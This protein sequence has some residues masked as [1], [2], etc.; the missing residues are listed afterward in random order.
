MSRLRKRNQATSS[1]RAASAVITSSGVPEERLGGV[2]R[3]MGVRRQADHPVRQPQRSPSWPSVTNSREQRPSRRSPTGCARLSS[4]RPRPSTSHTAGRLD[5]RGPDAVDAVAATDR[6]RDAG[7]QQQPGGADQGQPADRQ[8]QAVARGRGGQHRLG[9]AV[10]LVAGGAGDRG[11]AEAGDDHGDHGRQRETAACPAARRCRPSPRSRRGRLSESSIEPMLGTI[12][13]ISTP[14]TRDADGP[15]DQG[16]L[17]V[18]PGQGDGVPQ[19]RGARAPGPGRSGSS[20]APRSRRPRSAERRRRPG[21]RR[22]AGRAASTHTRGA[23]TRRCSWVPQPNGRQPAQPL[24]PTCP[25]RR[26][27]R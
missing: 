8:Q 20:P 9:P 12:E 17:L 6:R 24:A 11:D 2:L 27:A 22:A 4:T 19:P 25:P 10:V 15:A 3:H 21:R 5:Q 13:P 18:A 7:H 1:A 23:R 14:I 16:G 26:A